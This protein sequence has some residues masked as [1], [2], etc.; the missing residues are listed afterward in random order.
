MFYMS[1]VLYMV[2]KANGVNGARWNTL[3]GAYLGCFG[4]GSGGGLTRVTFSDLPC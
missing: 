1:T 3:P 4:G 2:M